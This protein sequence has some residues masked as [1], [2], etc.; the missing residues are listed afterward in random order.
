MADH[1][2]STP[3]D[4]ELEIE[5]DAEGQSPVDSH[6]ET[7]TASFTNKDVSKGHHNSDPSK[8]DDDAGVAEE[9]GDNDVSPLAGVTSVSIWTLFRYAS[10]EEKIAASIAVLASSAFGTALPLFSLVFG[11]ILDEYVV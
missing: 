2:S 9:N 7:I 10:T 4:V 1:H 6:T 5:A 8:G 11:E 3:V